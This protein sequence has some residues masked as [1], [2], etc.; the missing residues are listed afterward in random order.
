MRVLVTGANGFVGNAI[1][2]RLL[3]AGHDVVAATRRADAVPPGCGGAPAPTL[4]PEA[5]WRPALDRIDAVVH[6]AARVHVAGE[7]EADALPAFRRANVNGTV[8]LAEQAVE[9]GVRRF[10]FLSSVKALG[11]GKPD[12]APYTD[13]DRPEPLDPYGISKAEAE[14]ALRAVSERT[15]M[16]AVSL[17]PPLV[18]GPGGRGNFTALLRLVRSGLPLPFGGIDNRRSLIAVDNLADAAA[19]ALTHPA[20]SGGAFL[21]RDGEDVS[22]AELVRR[23]ARAIGRR[24]LLVP[25]PPVMIKAA[26]TAIGR[27]A[28]GPRLLGSLT[29][30][31][32]PFRR[33]VGWQ[34]PLGLD[35]GL[36]RA[37]GIREG[38]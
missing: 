18:Y 17:R 33:T 24:A 36:R 12:G 14:R 35:E 27:R 6:C 31:D 4:G 2:R 28:D 20:A 25:V 9:R 26:L 22:T 34:P 16:E 15:G 23:L 7:P 37:V 3:D 11:E 29:V 1:C 13:D 38:D 32:A 30:D 19:H 10:L 21:V 8:R 5:D